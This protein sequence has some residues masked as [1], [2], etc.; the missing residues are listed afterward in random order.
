MARD[1]DL[2]FQLIQLTLGYWR[3]QVLFTAHELGVFNALS[4]GDK[5]AEEIAG[6]C[7]S[8]VDRTER[9]LNA[10]V[11]IGLLKKENGRF[12]NLR[13]SETFLTRGQPR[14]MGNWIDLMSAWYRPW[15]NLSQAVRTGQPVENPLE[16]LGGQSDYTRFFIMAM[17]DYAIGPGKEMPNHLDLTG[18]KTLLDVG[19]GPGTYSIL[20]AQKNPQ[21]S[22]VVFDLPPV[23]EI[24]K[25]IISEYSLS[26]RVTVRGGSYLEDDL[27][28]GTN[29]FD[30]VLLSN[31]LHQEDPETCKM[32]LR[33]AKDALADDGLL[34]V[35]AMFL[36][37]EKDGPVW[38]TL[39]SLLLSLVYD[40]GRAYSLDET[41]GMIAE[42]GFSQPQVRR[43]SLLSAESLIIAKKN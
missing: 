43:I 33:K 3:S 35:Q 6:T 23:V 25:E 13:I 38:P 29:G 26:D 24:A 31:M 11:G 20:L 12:Q 34:V 8:S 28:N 36:N 5:S 22:A 32:I 27:R 2:I 4:G 15:E 19:G 40:G 16:H 21:L 7:S 9:L 42:T 30:V 14:Y 18:R 10:C 1:S 41:L 37:G 17:H 39:H